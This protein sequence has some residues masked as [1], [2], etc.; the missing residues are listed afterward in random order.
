MED[1]ITVEITWA[2]ADEINLNISKVECSLIVVATTSL[3]MTNRLLS[4]LKN[5]VSC[6]NHKRT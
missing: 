4:K 5:I 2:L 1:K 6:R 3:K